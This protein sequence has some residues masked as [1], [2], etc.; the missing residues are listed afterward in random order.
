MNRI[1]DRIPRPAGALP[2]S[3]QAWVLAGLTAVIAVTLVTFPGKADGTAGDGSGLAPGASGPATGAGVASVESGADRIR[4]EAAR[5]AEQRMREELGLDAPRSDGLPPPPEPVQAGAG[6]GQPGAYQDAVTADEQIEREER[7]RRYR[8][9]RAPALVQSARSETGGALAPPGPSG[10]AAAVPI[11]PDPPA[12]APRGDPSPEREGKRPPSNDRHPTRYVLR[13]G[14]FLE[15]VLA[16][17]LS[18]DYAG[19]V[20]AMV[21]SD[22]Y[23]R[24]RQRLL[25]P[26]GTRALGG[27]DPVEHW[28]QARLAVT[29]HRLVLP[30][31]TPVELTESVGLNQIGETGLRDRVQRHYPSTLAAAGA[32]GALAGL[33]Q[34]V[35]PGEA[36]VSRLG[37]ARLSAGSG[38]SQSSGRI[39]DRYLNRLPKVTVREG[40]RIRIYL[41]RDLTLPAY[42]GALNPLQGDMQ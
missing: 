28:G 29:F 20:N 36:F 35:S 1:V 32:V 14:E 17:R 16:N 39:L 2:A 31:G 15:A 21:S 24:S 42:R 34:A 30:N 8:A 18:G 12:A 33:S 10:T 25:V 3:A 5:R 38:L 6:P 22:V 40:H 26:R 27:A 37:S 7:I 9:L 19:P 23:D 4:E 41:T 11:A 13:E